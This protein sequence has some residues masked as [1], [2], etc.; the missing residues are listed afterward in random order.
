MA[1][2]PALN[3]GKII[4]DATTNKTGYYGPANGDNGRFIK[5]QCTWY[6]WGRAMEKYGVDL[7]FPEGQGNAYQ[8]YE[9]V[10][11][12][13]KIA[14]IEKNSTPLTDS[15]AVFKKVKEDSGHLLYIEAVRNDYTYFTEWNWNQSENGRLQRYSTNNL[16]NVH[17]NNLILQGY[18][19][20]R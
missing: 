3:L 11:Y 5:G 16:E 13:K 1:T 14:R 2:N 6:A 12:N 20:I 7:Q 10:Y 18:I 4:S 15:I 9:N 17:G 19:V 8:W